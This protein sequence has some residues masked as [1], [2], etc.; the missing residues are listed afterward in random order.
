MQ[1]GFLDLQA[2]VFGVLWL[3]APT[4]GAA[5]SRE[6]PTSAEIQGGLPDASFDTMFRKFMAP[7]T[8]FSPFYSWDAEMALTL[9]IFRRGQEAVTFRGVMHTIGTENLARKVSV[10]A[11][12]YV[13]GA[14][15]VHTSSPSLKLSVGLTHLSSHLTRD[16]DD[17]LEEE[18]TG[19]ATIPIV[20]DPDQYNV[21]FFKVHREVPLKAV[22]LAI[23]I[24]VEP[25]TFRFFSDPRV[26]RRPVYVASTW[27]LWRGDRVEVAAETQHEIGKNALNIVSLILKLY[28]TRQSEGRLQLFM[29]ASPGNNLYV[30]PNIGAFRGGVALGVRVRI[31]A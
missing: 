19:G 30:S 16:L 29:S 23:E 11:I 15:Y 3:L 12:G 26:N 9:T 1:R 28:G 4:T 25:I 24:A 21:F 7:E 27:G 5:Q 31:R 17:K 18:R 22:P 14:A 6:T 8:R 2:L 13:L 10:G 20:S